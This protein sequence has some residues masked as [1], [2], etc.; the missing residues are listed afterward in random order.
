MPVN[1]EPPL[2]AISLADSHYTTELIKET[3]EFVINVPTEELLPK[4]MAAGGVSGRK[5]DKFKKT[6]LTPKKA[7]KVSAPYIEECAGYLECRVKDS[8]SCDGVIVFIA[9]VLAAKAK[10][11]LF[12]GSWIP[13]KAKTVHHLGGGSFMISD[14]TVKA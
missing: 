11:A 12:S 4:L 2:V 13:E 3:G 1:D 6:G 5:E 8:K 14:R 9:E 10:E 7:E